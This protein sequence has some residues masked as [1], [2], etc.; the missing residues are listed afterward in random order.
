MYSDMSRRTM[1]VSS[2]N[3]NSA[4]ALVSSVLPTAGGAEEHERA[5]GTV[6]VLQAGAGAPHGGRD[7]LHRLAL[8]DD[9]AG[10]LVLHAQQLIL[11]A[12]QHPIH[13]DAGPARDDLGDVVGGDRLLD[14]GLLVLLFDGG[15]LLLQRGNRAVGEFARLRPVALALGVGE[16]RARL[17]ELLLDLGGPAE[18]VLLRLPARRHLSRLRLERGEVGLQTLQPVARTGVA[19]LLQRLLLDLELNDS[20][21]DL[22]QLLGLGIDLHAQ[23]RRGLVDEVDGLVGQEAVG[24]VAVRQRRRGNDGRI[25]DA[26]LVVLLVLLLEAAQ[27]RDGVLHRRLA[28][29]DRLEP[30]CERLVLLDVLAILVERRRAD[31]VQLAAGE[32]G[33]EQVRCVHGPVRLAGADEGVHLV[34]EQHDAAVGRGDL[35]EHGLQPLLELAAIFRA[36][37]QRAHVEGEDRLVLQAL[38]HVAVDDAQGEALHDGGLADAGLADEDRV[39][40]GAPR[41]HLDGAA[42]LLVAADDRVEL[43]LP[44]R[45]G[46]VAGIFLQRVIGVLGR[47]RIRGAALAQALDGRVQRLRCD[48]GG[49]QRLAGLGLLLQRQGEQQPLRRDEAVARLF[50][51]LLGGVE[52]AGEPLA[53]IDL[54]GP[55][56][57]HLRNLLQRLLGLLKRQLRLAAGLPDK[58]RG[59]ALRVVQQHLQ[60]VLR[61]EL[62]MAL[63]ERQRLRRLNEAARALGVLLDVHEGHSFARS[64]RLR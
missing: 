59:E 45:L 1:A 51:R 22:V 4:S 55:R 60:E 3:R 43:A 50:G 25:G 8:A 24:D 49:G 28:D 62:L 35:G 47:R 32:S 38:R 27:D 23:A 57:L 31:A 9:A 34:D 11:L 44:R 17:V 20:P 14:H 12:L 39:V 10:D 40:L 64:T 52:D 13:R 46:E 26:H 56:A 18:A 15:E 58:A 42:D 30:A 5:D 29:E 33:L 61:L 19:L 53:E 48:R 2:S 7:G 54:A 41:Q 37:D 6:R 63:A 36:G 16:G 21:V